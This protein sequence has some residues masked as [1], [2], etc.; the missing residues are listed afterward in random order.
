MKSRKHICLVIILVAT[1]LLV[2]IMSIKEG[3]QWG[4]DFA[5][6][7]AQARAISNGEIRQFVEDNTYIVLN[8]PVDMATPV[9]PWGFPLLMSVFVPFFGN[10]IIMYKV[11]CCIIIAL[12][13]TMLYLFLRQHLEDY[14]AFMISLCFGL[15]YSIL[16]SCNNVISDMLFLMLTLI[17][18]C[19]MNDY[20]EK[21]QNRPKMFILGLVIGYAYMTRS[22][23]IALLLSYF[24][25]HIY[26]IFK[27]K[28]NLNKKLF[29]TILPYCGFF[30]IYL[31][32][33][34]L[35]LHSERSSLYFL[36]YMDLKTFLSNIKYYLVVLYGYVSVP[37]NYKLFVYICMCFFVLIGFIDYV[38]IR[39]ENV[40]RISFSFLAS[41]ALI[42]INL[43]FPW[44][45][46]A[47][48]MLPVI[49][50]F[51]MF[52][53]MGITS[54]GK[55]L[56]MNN[57]YSIYLEILACILF[58]L[59]G[60]IY[61]TKQNIDNKRAYYKGA[62]TDQAVEMYEYIEQNTSE[63]D[64]FCFFKPRALYYQTGRLGFK[65]KEISYECISSADYLITCDEDDYIR[66]DD[67]NNKICEYNK[68]NGTNVSLELLLQNIKLSL[69]RINKR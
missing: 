57:K 40:E 14:K 8:S 61:Y 56:K 43:L 6:Y 46:G 45:Q 13:A 25:C 10:N 34:I 64:I 9:Y 68:E 21:E 44:H 3:H 37:N 16:K 7:L 4:D 28:N 30:V 20:F 32:D 26:L 38:F 69:Y 5:Q 15:D 67:L 22:Q 51:V 27:N 19:L 50:V 1:S 63:D 66:I 60:P 62:Y 59:F 58:S 49:P 47:R 54:T 48:Y 39:K 52:M 17:S 23:G 2:N 35:F 33:K 24:L 12:A 65:P 31:L 55:I 18:F 53:G 41:W 36:E 11:V 29:S 42:G